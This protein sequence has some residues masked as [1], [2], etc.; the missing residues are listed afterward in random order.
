MVQKV[1]FN[2]SDSRMKF[3]TEGDDKCLR[4]LFYEVGDSQTH[5]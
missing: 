2:M 1:I 5:A 3:S 4:Q